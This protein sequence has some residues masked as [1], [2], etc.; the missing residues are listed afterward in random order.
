MK[1]WD[2][3]HRHFI[4]SRATEGGIGMGIVS[5][6]RRKERTRRMRRR[7]MIAAGIVL[8]SSLAMAPELRETIA[9]LGRRGL[10]VFEQSAEAEM[11]LP[12]R[13]LVALQ[14]GV[15]DSGERAAEEA[16]RIRRTG[17][18]CV[19]WQREKMRIVCGVALSREKLDLSIA[20]G[21]DAYVIADTLP[22]VRLRIQADARQIE[23]VRM[24]IEAPDEILMQ[25]LTGESEL[26]ELVFKAKELAMKEQNEHPEHA[27]YTELAGSIGNWCRLME[28]TMA[29]CSEEEARSYAAVTIC[30]LCREL[31]LALQRQASAQST[32]SAQRTPSTAADV[33]P[34]A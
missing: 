6:R 13:E 17:V 20:K 30:T 28:Q 16:E 3:I 24:L 34:P 11:T 18:P 22:K 2:K 27:L 4:G 15:F 7:V 8:L 21:N 23:R 1:L 26:P 25:L 32:A 5:E 33:M 14:L 19:V 29:E 31:R 9:D 10:P 12:K